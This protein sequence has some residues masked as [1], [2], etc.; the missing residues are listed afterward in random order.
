M[1][2]PLRRVSVQHLIGIPWARM[3][4]AAIAD[5][6]CLAAGICLPTYAFART[7]AGDATALVAYLDRHAPCWLEIGTEAGAARLAGDIIVSRTQA[8]GP[9]LS[10]LVDEIE[11]RAITTSEASHAQLIRVDR[12]SEVVKVIRWML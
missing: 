10:V 12:I 9:H 4:C 7:D 11:R 8:G 1:V 2:A 6:A 3:D 5:A